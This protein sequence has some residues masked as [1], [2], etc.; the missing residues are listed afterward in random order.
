[1]ADDTVGTYLAIFTESARQAGLDM[2]RPGQ[3]WAPMRDVVPGSHI[4]LSVRRDAIQVNL[5]NERDQD[6]RRFNG[7]YRDREAIQSAIGQNLAWEK[8]DGRKKTA[9]RATLSRGYDDRRDWQEQHRWAITTMA[10]FEKE[11]G[12]RLRAIG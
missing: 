6:R 2:R 4:S 10:A 1:M 8:K 3:N 5:N 7:L 11:F 9:I 12:P